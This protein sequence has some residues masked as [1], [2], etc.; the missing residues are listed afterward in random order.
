[1]LVFECGLHGGLEAMVSFVIFDSVNNF[2]RA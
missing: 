1:M 2:V